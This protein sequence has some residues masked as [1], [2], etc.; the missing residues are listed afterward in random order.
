VCLCV[1]V[2]EL[3]NLFVFFFACRPKIKISVL[4]L[5]T[6]QQADGCWYMSDTVWAGLGLPSDSLG[7]LRE[8]LAAKKGS[9]LTETEERA[10]ATQLVLDISHC[11]LVKEDQKRKEKR[12][13]EREQQLQQRGKPTDEDAGGGSDNSNSSSS[14]DESCIRSGHTYDSLDG[15]PGSPRFSPV[16]PVLSSFSPLFCCVALIASNPALGARIGWNKLGLKYVT[17]HRVP[18][19]WLPDLQG[20]V[21]ASQK[22]EEAKRSCPK[23]GHTFSTH[24]ARCPLCTEREAPPLH[25]SGSRDDANGYRFSGVAGPRDIFLPVNWTLL[26]GTKR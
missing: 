10:V 2:Y 11:E 14:S 5:A 3:S 26:K 4:Q 12:R 16:L 9:G 15:T 23:C 18:R 7:G 25:H 8:K 6:M 19:E 21:E 24:R 22:R 20:L 13:I 17:R 1:C